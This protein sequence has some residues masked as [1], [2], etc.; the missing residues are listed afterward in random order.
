MLLPAVR[1]GNRGDCRDPHLWVQQLTFVAGFSR[2]LSTQRPDDLRLREVS[3]GRPS[4][5][6]ASGA[7]EAK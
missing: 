6:R 2:W 4:Y 7:D 5:D 3:M 1:R